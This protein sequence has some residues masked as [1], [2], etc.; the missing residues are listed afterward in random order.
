[1]RAGLMWL[2]HHVIPMPRPWLINCPKFKSLSHPHTPRILR[3]WGTSRTSISEYRHDCS[4]EVPFSTAN[5][6]TY[7]DTFSG[8]R[9]YPG[10]VRISIPSYRVS[11]R[12]CR[13][14]GGKSRRHRPRG[15]FTGTCWA[16]LQREH[17]ANDVAK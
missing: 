5:M 9:I 1:M 8:Q 4:K 16:I 17:T 13:R 14:G 10:K 7:D 2:C 6:R 12:R 15:A 11:W 3:N